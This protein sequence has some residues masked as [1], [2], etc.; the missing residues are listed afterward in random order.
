MKHTC[1]IQTRGVHRTR[2][3]AQPAGPEPPPPEPTNLMMISGGSPPTEL[4]PFRSASGFP[5]QKPKPL[6]ST[7]KSTK[8]GKIQRFSDKELLEIHCNP[9]DPAIFFIFQRRATWNPHDLARSHQD[10]LQ[11][12]WIWPNIGQISTDTVIYRHRWQNP[13][14]NRHQPETWRIRTGWSDH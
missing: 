4:D 5:P 2:S 9:P 13:K 7:I 11:I 6:D 1:S 3:L 8:S 12:R 10:L 14:L